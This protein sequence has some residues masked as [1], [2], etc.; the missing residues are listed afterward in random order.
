MSTTPEPP[1]ERAPTRHDG[2]DPGTARLWRVG[3][4][5]WAAVGVLAVLAVVGYVVSLL[6]LVVIP[7][8]LALFP[9]TLLV[10][11]AGWLK[12]RG[13][14]AA[15]AAIA[16]LLGGILLIAALVGAMIPLVAAELPELTESASEGI[17]EVADLLERQPFGL[18]VGG[19]DEI[20]ATAQDQLPGVGEFAGEALE[21]A[22]T[23][24]ETSVGLVLML[25]LVFFYLKDGRRLAEGL[26]SVAPRRHRGRALEVMERA[27]GTLG[28]YF[29][30]Q[31]LVALV[32]AVV[33]GLG[34]LVLGVPLALPLAVLIFFG[35]LFPIVGAVVT[36]AL[37]VLV[38]LADGGLV[39]GLIVLGLVLLVQQLESNVLEPIIL[40]RAI[41][42]HPLVVLLSITAGGVLI[43]ILGAFLAVP[44]AAI[45]A[46]VIDYIRG[47][48][49][50]EETGTTS[51]GEDT[52]GEE[53]EDVAPENAR[54]T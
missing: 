1:P 44:V 12:R 51:D 24:V 33:I 14:P 25:V 4:L 19:L 52:G 49:W 17:A 2:E 10:P 11:L 16:S 21:A 37:A 28:A 29:R 13:A 15:L 54:V 26:A 36:G 50:A 45:I 43:G 30:G 8:M 31:L 40:A 42:L 39:V 47:D 18:D 5:A 46:N 6:P 34:L 22:A 27:W 9:A 7:V 23:A 32:D 20:L 38:A 41:D 48:G 3:G 53:D 35:G